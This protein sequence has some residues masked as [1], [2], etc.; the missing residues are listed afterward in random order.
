MEQV[1]LSFLN[2]SIAAGWLVLAL[3]LLRPALKKVPKAV[4][5]LL[6]GLVGVRLVCPFSPESALSLMPSAEAVP[7]T[8][9]T[10]PA[11]QIDT[12]LALFNS[13]VHG[14]LDS[15]FRE[16]AP[17]AGQAQSIAAVLA[18]VWIAGAALMGLWALAS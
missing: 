14:Y 7:R 9:L 13:T 10:R 11:P 12:G 6:W 16:A 4:R 5:C 15:R 17:P 3:V 2:R 18:W 1:F 8:A